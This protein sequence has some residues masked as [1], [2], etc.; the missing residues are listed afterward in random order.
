MPGQ[1]RTGSLRV[2]GHA[3]RVLCVRPL[4]PRYLPNASGLHAMH[5]VPL[6]CAGLNFTLTPHYCRAGR[7]EVSAQ[8][9]N[10]A[11]D[12]A[13]LP[14][15][16]EVTHINLN[17]GTCAGACTFM[18]CVCAGEIGHARAGV[19]GVEASRS[20]RHVHGCVRAA[21][22]RVCCVRVRVCV[23]GRGRGT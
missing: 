21:A 6:Y 12:P 10:F 15:G 20:R 13:S 3:T 4:A 1:A 11:V 9:H 22:P 2:W 23:L 18:C 14:A 17:D 7:I 19:W 8:N 5:A 16:V